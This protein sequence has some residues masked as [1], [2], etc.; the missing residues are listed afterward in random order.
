MSIA[1]LSPRPPFCRYSAAVGNFLARQDKMIFF[2][3]PTRQPQFG[4]IA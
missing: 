2:F 1:A 4:E 3:L